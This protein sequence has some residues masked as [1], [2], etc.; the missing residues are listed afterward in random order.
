M[1]DVV[2]EASSAPSL[3]DVDDDDDDRHRVVAGPA[4]SARSSRGPPPLKPA[5]SSRLTSPPP[6]SKPSPDV[7]DHAVDFLKT[8]DGMDKMLKLMRYAAALTA[9]ATTN[10]KLSKLERYTALTRKFLRLGRFLGNAKELRDLSRT[11]RRLSRL[12]A[13]AT[14]GGDDI[15]R[16]RHR[17]SVT[18]NNLAIACQGVQLAYNLLE[19]G[20]WATRTRLVTNE[21]WKRT[22]SVGANY[23]ELA[24]CFFSAQLHALALRDLDRRAREIAD[25]M[26]ARRRVAAAAAAKVRRAL[27]PLHATAFARCTPLL[28]DG[29]S[30]PAPRAFLSARHPS[31]SIPTRPD[32]PARRDASRLRD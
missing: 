21:R 18:V 9:L 6:E 24:V 28:E 15:A 3:S 32:A 10:A 26:E 23:A 14:A 29:L 4:S 1:S 27:V 5:S 2:S 16:Q 7:L 17:A 20:N 13:T 25:A 12:G 8:R 30:V 22:F 19:Q 11:S 31:L